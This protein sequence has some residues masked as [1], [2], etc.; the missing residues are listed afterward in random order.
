MPLKEFTI[1]KSI[2]DY[3]TMIEKTHKIYWF[4]SASGAVKTASGR[5]FK[6][7]KSG[8]PDITICYQDKF[9]GIELKTATGRQS[10]PQKQAQSNIEAAGGLYYI[11]RELAELKRIIESFNYVVHQDFNE[12]PKLITRSSLDE[13]FI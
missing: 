3:L 5:F 1:Q 8:V 9:V 6:T 11:V 13:L 7:G 12:N 4:R 2:M 10:E